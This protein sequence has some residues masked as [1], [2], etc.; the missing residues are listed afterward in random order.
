MRIL[1]AE[2]EF[3]SRMVLQEILRPYGRIDI[4][5]DGEEAVNLAGLAIESGD[6][7]DLICLD[8][9]MPLKDGQQ[10]LAEIRAMEEAKGITS[11]D[12]SKILMITALDDP[13]NVFGAFKNLC[14]AYLVKPIVKDKLFMEM[15]KLRLI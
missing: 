3:T 14:D 9:M 15:N 13:K 6:R 10:A 7:Y 1:I 11:S 8:I 5:V 4:A 2:D 12:G